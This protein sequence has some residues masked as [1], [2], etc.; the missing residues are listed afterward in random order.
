MG[1]SLPSDGS[2]RGQSGIGTLIILVAMILVATIAAG[3]FFDTIGS[4]QADAGETSEESASQVTTRLGVVNVVGT[5]ISGDAVGTVEVTVRSTSQSGQIDLGETVAQWLGPGGA[6]DLT[7]AE[8]ADSDHFSVVAARDDDDSID[9]DGVLNDPS[10][11]ATLRF[12]AAAING[13]GLASGETVTIQLNTQTGGT[14]DVHLVI[15]EQLP[16]GSFVTL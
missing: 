12:D 1:S 6:A 2:D 7:K 14:T 16:D 13:D 3:V 10:D 11:R 15:P 8:T 9:G 4:L 5:D